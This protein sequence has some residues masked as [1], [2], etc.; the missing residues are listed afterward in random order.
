M[1]NANDVYLLLKLAG[2]DNNFNNK[3]FVPLISGYCVYTKL[4]ET[5]FR[6]NLEWCDKE[7]TIL[8]RWNNFANDFTFTNVQQYEEETD[9]KPESSIQKLTQKGQ[10]GST[11][12]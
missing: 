5:Y 2:I 10:L 7:N 9:N 4:V 6:L 1:N 3:V 12:L 11:I 8:Y